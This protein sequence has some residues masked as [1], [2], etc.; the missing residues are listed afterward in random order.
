MT[1]SDLTAARSLVLDLETPIRESQAIAEL[2]IMLGTARAVSDEM[3]LVLDRL[4][5]D[6]LDR[7]TELRRLFNAAHEALKQGEA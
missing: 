3:R 6:L 1:T 2:L 5:S 4:G 7:V